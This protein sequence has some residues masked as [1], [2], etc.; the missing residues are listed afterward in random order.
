L[1]SG[2]TPTVL[3]SHAAAHLLLGH[4]DEAK[5]DIIEAQQSAAAKDPAVL[6]VAA[7]LGMPQ[8]LE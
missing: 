8:G 3:A 4:V 2:R 1:P 7:T 6:A 5:A